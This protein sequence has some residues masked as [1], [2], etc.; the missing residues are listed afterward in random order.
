[1]LSQI[2]EEEAMPDAKLLACTIADT[3]SES[4]DTRAE[5]VA[6]GMVVSGV[7]CETEPDD[8]AELVD[9]FCILLRQSVASTLN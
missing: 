9:A 5:L 6:L 1:M 3:L 8:R 2:M 7:I 4:K